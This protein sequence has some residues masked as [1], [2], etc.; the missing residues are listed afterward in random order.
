MN[1][2]QPIFNLNFAS[3]CSLLLVV[4]DLGD[5]WTN[6]DFL[7]ILSETRLVQIE[8]SR[9]LIVTFFVGTMV[10][11]KP[12]NVRA[13]VEEQCSLCLVGAYFHYGHILHLVN[14]FKLHFQILARR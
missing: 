6:L 9:L 7:V 13:C 4:G 14:V 2:T 10:R 12:K 5:I 8:G 3:T 11:S 1:E